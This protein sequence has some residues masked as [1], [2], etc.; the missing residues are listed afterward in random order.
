MRYRLLI[1]VALAFL[2][3][4]SGGTRPPIIEIRIEKCPPQKPKIEYLDEKKCPVD[5]PD[6]GTSLRSLL[7]AWEDL[8]LYARCKV[9]T[10]ELWNKN[11]DDCP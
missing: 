1:A 6:K 4:C 8:V 10:A 11:W 2:V 7:L 9:A 5:I 3:G